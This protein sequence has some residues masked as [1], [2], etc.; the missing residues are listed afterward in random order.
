VLVPL[1]ASGH[2]LG[3]LAVVRA[4]CGTPF[5]DVD[6]RMV[7]AF[8]GHAALTL[9]FAR[10]EEDRQQLAV[11]QD[12]DRI[13]RDLHDLVI[14]RLFAVGLG[15]Q[16]MAR[17]VARPDGAERIAGF[18]RDLDETIAEIR[19][20]IF[21]LQQT[22]GAA[23]S[24][25]ARML[26]VATEFAGPLGFEPHVRLEGPIDTLTSD[27]VR[28]DLVATLRE[29]LSNIARHAGASSVEILVRADLPARQV[30]LLVRDD[31]TGLPEHTSRRSGLAN[32]A[33]RARR[34]GGKLT[35]QSP[36]G[37]GTTLTWS[38]GTS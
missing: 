22:P 9:E 27:D 18:V 20:S 38:A 1:A 34:H 35:V 31:G 37:G 8:A 2:V 24:L 32:L 15:L 30:Q 5:T 12:R 3:V 23:T 14:Q 19:R 13:A 21:S 4:H 28:A 7:T 6:V 25:R 10:A 26:D 16:G 36:P 33:G 11:F 17:F 29:A